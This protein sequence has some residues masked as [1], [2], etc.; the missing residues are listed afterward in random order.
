MEYQDDLS[1]YDFFKKVKKDFAYQF[2]TAYMLNY[3]NVDGKD[4]LIP[5]DNRA[6]ILDYKDIEAIIKGLQNFLEVTSQEAIDNFNNAKEKR[7]KIQNEFQSKNHKNKDKPVENKGIVYLLKIEN[8]PQYKIGVTNN[9]NRRL[10]QI[11]PK[12]PFEL[13]VIHTIKDNQIYKL[14]E[15]LHNKFKDKKIKGEW[16]KLNDNDVNYIK[17]L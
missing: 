15:K 4:I 11:S 9:L 3:D 12:M 16:F 7:Q 17:G 10:K 8:K 14:E 5:R 2:L 6:C 1:G 13:K